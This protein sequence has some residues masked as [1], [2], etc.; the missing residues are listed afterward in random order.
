MPLNSVYGEIR[1]EE[2][3]YYIGRVVDSNLSMLRIWGGGIYES[4]HFL[5]LC[6]E[7]GI[8][9]FQDMMLA[10]GIFRCV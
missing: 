1:E 5:D 2:Y 7:N 10:C 6:D 9:I 8:M 4:E 3:D